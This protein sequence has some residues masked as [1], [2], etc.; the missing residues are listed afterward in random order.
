[1]AIDGLQ[2]SFGFLDPQSVIL[3]LLRVHLLFALPLAGR[4][5]IS[6]LLLLL[7]LLAVLFRKLL[8]FPA[9]WRME[10]CTGHRAPPLSLL[11]T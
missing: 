6:T 2:V 4:H 3:V 5:A 1:M 8:D 10:L 11:D 7:Q 9:L